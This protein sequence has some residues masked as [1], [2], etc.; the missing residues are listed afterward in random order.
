MAPMWVHGTSV[1]L[2]QVTAPEHQACSVHDAPRG[3]AN[4]RISL[5]AQVED[6]VS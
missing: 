2:D 6:M 1:C 4:K 3:N 5:N